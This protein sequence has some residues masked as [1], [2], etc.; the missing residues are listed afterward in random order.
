MKSFEELMSKKSWQCLVPASL[1]LY[2]VIFRPTFSQLAIAAVVDRISSEVFLKV[3]SQKFMNKYKQLK[4]WFPQFSIGE[5][6]KISSESR[7]ANLEILSQ[8][9]NKWTRYV[10]FWDYVRFL[11]TFLIMIFYWDHSISNEMQALKVGIVYCFINIGLIG[12][13][14]FETNQWILASV[15]ELAEDPTWR[16]QVRQFLKSKSP[17]DVLRWEPWVLSII[18]FYMLAMQALLLSEAESFKEIGLGVT[19]PVISG[20]LI[21]SRVWYLSRQIS[22]IGRRYI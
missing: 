11:P 20:S 19:L 14:G 10:I 1:I 5:F 8:I 9:P 16:D 18:A 12:L 13:M 22:T 7:S 15:S 4:R 2:M 6:R 21:G 3:A 17:V